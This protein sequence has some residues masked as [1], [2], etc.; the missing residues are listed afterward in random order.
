MTNKKLVFLSMV[1]PDLDSLGLLAESLKRL[2]TAEEYEFIVSNT[3]IKSI[4][5]DELIRVIQDTNNKS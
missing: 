4:P 1:D 5:R 3:E 2:D